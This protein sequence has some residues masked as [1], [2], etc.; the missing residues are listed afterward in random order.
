M[1][2]SGARCCVRPALVCWSEAWW[3]VRPALVL[4]WGMVLCEASTCVG[5]GHGAV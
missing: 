4:E 5:V 3:Y 1:C 2:W